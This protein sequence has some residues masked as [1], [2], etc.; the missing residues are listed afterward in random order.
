MGRSRRSRRAR[1]SR[2]RA[3][4][5]LLAPARKPASSSRPTF[6]QLTFRRGEVGCGALRPGRPDDRLFR[7]AG[8]ASPSRC[9]ATAPESARVPALRPRP[10]R[11]C[12]RSRRPGEMAVSLDRHRLRCVHPHRHAGADLGRRR[13]APREILDDVQWADWAPG[14]TGRWRSSATSASGIAWSIRSAR[15][16]SRRPAGSAIRASPER[17]RDRA[18]STTRPGRRRRHGR[19]RRPLGQE[20]GRHAGCTPRSRASP[21]ARRPRDLVHG[22]RGRLQSGGPCG[23]AVADKT[24]LVGR[25]RGS[26]PSGTSRKDGRVLMTNES[27]PHRRPRARPG[28]GRRSASSRGS[29]GRSPRDLSPDGKTDPVRRRS[30]EGGGPGLLG[31]P[32]RDRRLPGGASRRRVRGGVLARRAWAL[33]P[34]RTTRKPRSSL[35]PDERGEPRA[36][37][38]EGICEP[39]RPTSLPDGKTIVFTASEAGPWLRVCISGTRGRKAARV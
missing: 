32:A 9:S 10:A 18:S 13:V 28:R 25:V 1:R 23:D 7:R 29:T 16:S 38:D 12:S 39:V 19:D 4:V 20:D 14:R 35:L 33:G 26:A 37:P 30:G 27:D 6:R 36:L 8:T 21:G 15:S 2:S 34:D 11:R 31:L 24:R 3:R 5:V 17:R 22:R